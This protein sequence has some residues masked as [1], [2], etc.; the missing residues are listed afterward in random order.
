[1]PGPCATARARHHILQVQHSL[2]RL[3]V[4]ETLRAFSQAIR[5]PDRC[6]ESLALCLLTQ[7][8]QVP[9]ETFLS[10]S[11]LFSFFLPQRSDLNISGTA[12][13]KQAGRRSRPCENTDIDVGRRLAGWLVVGRYLHPHASPPWIP[14]LTLRAQQSHENPVLETEPIMCESVSSHSQTMKEKKKCKRKAKC[15]LGEAAGGEMLVC[16]TH[17]GGVLRVLMLD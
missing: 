15:G 12:A 10:F 3:D 8:P 13:G 17:L 4:V 16:F 6:D 5:G 9:C 2:Q 1:M 7:P 11:P 14:G